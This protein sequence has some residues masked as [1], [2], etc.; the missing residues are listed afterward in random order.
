MNLFD[1]CGNHFVV[2]SY[3]FQIATMVYPSEKQARLKEVL[4][5]AWITKINTDI[6]FICR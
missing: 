1:S 3:F 5:A 2:F 6:T 4:T